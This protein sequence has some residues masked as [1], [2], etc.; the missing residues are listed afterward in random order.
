MKETLHWRTA[1]AYPGRIAAVLLECREHNREIPCAASSSG[2][3]YAY[4][5]T[6]GMKSIS[7]SHLL[8]VHSCRIA[9]AVY[10][11]V[12]SARPY[13]VVLQPAAN[14]MDHGLASWQQR[15]LYSAESFGNP[16]GPAN[17]E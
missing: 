10:I 13:S 8:A 16:R 17:G 3:G 7:L 11:N 4:I 6:V 14:S 12:L 5:G 9:V 15:C 2:T 1:A